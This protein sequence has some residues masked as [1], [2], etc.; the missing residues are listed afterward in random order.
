M[1]VI[2]QDGNKIILVEK[3]FQLNN[4]QKDIIKEFIES[5]NEEEHDG[6]I[7]TLKLDLTKSQKE[8]VIKLKNIIISKFKEYFKVTS[9]EDLI[10]ILKNEEYIFFTT[11]SMERLN[12]R[13]NNKNVQSQSP[14]SK[15]KKLDL[16]SQS[17]ESLKNDAIQTFID[18]NKVDTKVE[19]P[20]KDEETLKSY[21]RINYYKDMEKLRVCVEIKLEEDSSLNNEMFLIITVITKEATF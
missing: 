1:E 4:D 6:N 19:Y 17:L 8:K 16:P 21:P 9:D 20:P 13:V 2:Y 12:Q 14:F 7:N 10:D 18:S 5:I 15:L 11:H 3:M